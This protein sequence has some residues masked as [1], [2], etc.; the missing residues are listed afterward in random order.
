MLNR[1]VL[2]LLLIFLC[3][4]VDGNSAV[5]NPCISRPQ[6][7]EDEASQVLENWT[8]NV[9]LVDRTF[10]C[11]LTCL[12]MDLDLVSSSGQVQIDKYL[13]A[14]VVD[15]KYWAIELVTCRAEFEDEKDVCELSYGMFNCF[16]EVKLE[17]DKRASK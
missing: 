11:L 9:T 14:G 3:A 13:K 16:R 8:K 1:Q 4:R 5:F 2:H 12:L 17:F 10:K 6:L 7:T 15:W